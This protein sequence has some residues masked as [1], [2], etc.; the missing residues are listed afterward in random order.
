MSHDDPTQ[1]RILVVDDNISIQNDYRKILVGDDHS[2]DLDAME[3]DLFGA[4]LGEVSPV[5]FD[6]DF[7]LQGQEALEKVEAAIAEGRPYAMAFVD[8]RMPPSWDGVETLSR[9]SAVD[10]RV[11]GVL[12]TAYTDHSWPSIIRKL[13]KSDRLLILKKPFDAIEI[14][15]MALTLTTKWLMTRSADT[16]LRELTARLT[17]KGESVAA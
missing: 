7:A 8:V 10:S 9:I 11:Q 2:A 5:R 6:L 16:R 4:A 1:P 12:C 13:G 15:Q 17:A 3:S 14:R